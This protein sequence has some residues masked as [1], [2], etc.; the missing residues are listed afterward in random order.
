M[1]GRLTFGAASLAGITSTCLVLSNSRSVFI[2][3]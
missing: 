3:I 2:P 1:C